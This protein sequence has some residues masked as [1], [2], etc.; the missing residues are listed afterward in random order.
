MQ[1][2]KVSSEASSGIGAPP[3]GGSMPAPPPGVPPPRPPGMGIRGG[4]DGGG[5][6]PLQP[7]SR[8]VRFDG[9][10]KIRSLSCDDALA[11]RP[12]TLDDEA[13]ESNPFG[14]VP[15]YGQPAAQG[16]NMVVAVRC[17][18]LHLHE[19]REGARAII[20]AAPD[21][22]V[23]ILEDPQTTAADDYLRI[24]KSKERRYAFDEVFCEYVA[25][26][27]V[28]EKTTRFLINGVLQGF[29]AT[30]FA[31]GATGAG[32]THTMIGSP[33]EPGVM[34]LTLL[35][36]FS[37]ADKQREDRVFEVK[38]SF[39]E[40]YNENIRDLLRPE[41]DYLDIREDP[42]KGMCVAGISEV[43]GLESANEIMSLLHHANRARTTEATG[44]NVTSSR[45]HAVLQVVVEQRDRTAGIVAEVNLG[46]LSMIDLAGS[47]RASQTN[48]K[49]MRMIEGANINRS[50]LALGN[51]ITA[52]S[53]AVAFVPYRDS[54]MTRLLKDSL[55]GNCRTVM[56][57]NVSPNHTNYEDTHNTLKYANRAKNIKTKAVQN[58][59][60]VNCH[61]SKYTE[62]IKDLRVEISDL[63]RKLAVAG[64]D[65]AAAG[66]VPM[67]PENASA[68]VVPEDADDAM[69]P[70]PS[71]VSAAAC[72]IN[73]AS[74]SDAATWKAELMQNFEERVRIK[75]KLIDLAH[76][77][78]NQMGQRIHAQVGIS[79]WE[80][81]QVGQDG[82]A[83][84]VEKS[85]T[86]RPIRDLQEK[87]KNIKAGMAHTEETTQTLED[88]LVQNQSQAER[89]Q[90]ELPKRVQNKDMR[91][92]LALVS[93][94]YV[95]EVENMDLQEMNDVTA[96]LIQ[97]KELE[98]EALRL[99][100]QMR[101]RMIAEQDDMCGDPLDKP[102]G[103]LD[104]PQQPQ[105][106]H[107]KNPLIYL[108]Q[109]SHAAEVQEMHE[110][111]VGRHGGAG[112]RNRQHSLSPRA[113]SGLGPGGGGSVGSSAPRKPPPA[114]G[115]SEHVNSPNRRRRGEERDGFFPREGR[116]RAGSEELGGRGRGRMVLPPLDGQQE[117]RP[118]SDRP[119][120][121]TPTEN[122]APAPLFRKPSAD[123]RPRPGPATH[124]PPPP[125]HPPYHSQG[126]RSD[127][128]Y[129]AG[130]PDPAFNAGT[131][132]PTSDSQ[133][134][135]PLEMAGKALGR[136]PR[137]GIPGAA[138]A[139]AFA[140][141]GHP[142]TPP[143]L[144]RDGSLG[145]HATG[146]DNDWDHTRKKAIVVEGQQ[147]L[148]PARRPSERGSREDGSASGPALGE[149]YAAPAD[150]RGRLAG[151]PSGKS[152]RGRKHRRSDNSAKQK[153]LHGVLLVEA[154]GVKRD[155][156]RRD[157]S[158]GR[159]GDQDSS[160][161]DSPAHRH[162]QGAGSDSERQKTPSRK[163][164][165][166]RKKEL[167]PKG[168]VQERKGII[169]K[170]NKRMKSNESRV[171]P[172]VLT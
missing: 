90:A 148:R 62:I 35:D 150:P 16:H 78:R 82:A 47:E 91:S 140:A 165:P 166:P 38:C 118:P 96:P 138:D 51:C 125:P 56:I 15:S 57:A 45:S 52:L 86:P 89:L 142:K 103:W 32:K 100:I 53:S 124:T 79:Q 74:E 3:A 28:Y 23:V 92:F 22:K 6:A 105:N 33:R 61:V 40:V 159:S 120:L 69:G 121:A 29:N 167:H 24:N 17:R 42:V 161:R 172:K 72:P 77:A 117:Q 36:L 104:I 11:R 152:R 141:A 128:P 106:R 136:P 44:A 84:H 27:Q 66:A 81:S 75:R 168:A 115:P 111:V 108:S 49:G 147:A 37:E 63:K 99:Q 119:H 5:Y 67:P 65:N 145:D 7:R 137:L 114:A 4:E 143:A 54:K 85:G 102:D 2:R 123:G 134:I 156:E 129:S 110:H 14:R 139:E 93:R 68:V 12:V 73:V 157:E 41:G 170:L 1:F 21:G 144:P 88:Q 8:A 109:D 20:K 26:R 39:L 155:K 95:L 94:I 133:E 158:L 48:N 64:E 131:A 149:P 164:T 153:Q 116:S 171:G 76:E 112:A 58:V 101:D 31:Y 132:A 13:E 169:E 97:Q 135:A 59:V 146:A 107:L 50:L 154:S 9:L 71:I 46:K 122:G 34:M 83:S 70:K 162:R 163:P 80:S 25:T 30:V 18:P 127:R 19:I 151:A 55:G 10:P 160:G 126:Q 130:T 60:T 98:A 113:A 43:G 87:L